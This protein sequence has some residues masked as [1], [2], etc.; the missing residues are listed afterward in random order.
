[1]GIVTF[2]DHMMATDT[3]PKAAQL[4]VVIDTSAL[5]PGNCWGKD[6]RGYIVPT[7]H[8]ACLA[9]LESEGASEGVKV[10]VGASHGRGDVR[11]RCPDSPM[12]PQAMEMKARQLLQPILQQ[13]R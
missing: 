11:I 3:T 10:V 2:F 7:F 6:R 9:A 8:R 4:I 13:L 12:S 1:L 5:E